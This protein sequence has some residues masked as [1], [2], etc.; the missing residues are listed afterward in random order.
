MFNRKKIVKQNTYE[1]NVEFPSQ[2]MQVVR[3]TRAKGSTTAFTSIPQQQIR[4]AVRRRVRQS[5]L[6]EKPLN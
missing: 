3:V 2:A 1:E 4:G 6:P 5:P